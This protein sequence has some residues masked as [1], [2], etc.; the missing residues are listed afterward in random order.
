MKC[1]LSFLLLVSF[2][3]MASAGGHPNAGW[4]S[5]G[6]ESAGVCDYA[7]I[8]EALDAVVMATESIHVVSGTYNETLTIEDISVDIVGGYADCAL[9]EEDIR[10][11][12]SM[13]TLDAVD[14]GISI[15]NMP[16]GDTASVNISGFNVINGESAF[17]LS[18]GGINVSGDVTVFLMESRVAENEGTAGGGIFVGNAATLFLQNTLIEENDAYSGGGVYCDG[19]TL[20]MNG[21][22]GISDNQ[23][24][25]GPVE[26]SGGGLYLINEA[27]ASVLSGS[28]NPSTD[29]FGFHSNQASDFGGGIYVNDSELFIYGD[30]TAFGFGSSTEPVNI[31]GNSAGDSGGGIYAT[32]GSVVSATVIDMR[33]NNTG[34]SGAA[35]FIEDGSSLTIDMQTGENPLQGC[36]TTDKT[37]CNRISNNYIANG[38]ETDG[39]GGAIRSLNSEV[40]LEHVW[41]ENNSASEGQGAVI[42]HQGQFGEGLWIENSVMYEN[43]TASGQDESIIRSNFS[44]VNMRFN[45]L[46]D[47]SMSQHIVE[48]IGAMGHDL[49][50]YNN[51]IHNDNGGEVLALAAVGGVPNITVGCVLVHDD[52][53]LPAVATGVFVGDPNFYNREEGDLHLTSDSHLAVDKCIIAPDAVSVD[54]DREDRI[55]DVPGMGNDLSLGIVDIGA[56]EFSGNDIDLDI[57]FTD[58]FD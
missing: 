19:C 27:T 37:K 16:G 32:N 49:N 26:S 5:V 55:H 9:A 53:T 28:I 38:S 15:S 7:S 56:D 50:L 31:T 20:V 21:A 34:D 47:N 46:V 2:S 41:F 40:R 11:T 23:A 30:V 43:G 22:S 13:S 52:S 36:W 4:V 33:N 3:A 10:T 39:E 1:V 44:D 6:P 24:T 29:N 35:I 42:R 14:H 48:L 25:G 51:I 54:V 8:Q 57:I 18:A 17:P 58:G 12:G 45:T